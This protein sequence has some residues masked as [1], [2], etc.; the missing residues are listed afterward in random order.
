M[1]SSARIVAL[2][3]FA[4]VLWTPICTSA[5]TVQGQ[6]LGGQSLGPTFGGGNIDTIFRAAASAWEQAIRDDFTVTLNYGWGSSPGGTHQLLIQG[7]SPNRELVGEIRVNAQVFNDGSFAQLFLDPTPFTN[8]EFTT[9]SD[10]TQDFGGGA[11]NVERRYAGADEISVQLFQDL[12]SIMAHEIGHGL[13][14]SNAN[15]S[16]M[17]EAADVNIIVTGSL[18]FAGTIIPLATNDAGVTSHIDLTGP[19]MS[20]LGFNDRRLP[21]DLDI[22]ANAQLSGFRNLN[23][24]TVPEPPTLLLLASGLAVLLRWRRCLS[25]DAPETLR[26]VMTSSSRIRCHIPLVSEICGP[27]DQVSPVTRRAS[28]GSLIH[29]ERPACDRRRTRWALDK[30]TRRGAIKVLRAASTSP[31]TALKALE[32]AAR[33][34]GQLDSRSRHQE[35]APDRPS[36]S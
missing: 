6:F 3:V 14:I 22:L 25:D 30:A 10:R 8:E 1:L 17:T 28:E 24:Q 35:T 31:R 13:G 33:L 21:T 19:V 9:F 20:G 15:T 4:L 16:F 18:P 32:L 5:I 11:V 27:G 26:A 34:N 12:W 29:R 23:L 2:S 7:G 36:R